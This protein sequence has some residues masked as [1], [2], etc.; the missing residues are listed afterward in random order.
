MERTAL[1][2]LL[3]QKFQTHRIIGLLG[4]RQCGKTTLAKAYCQKFPDFSR[5]NYFDLENPNDLG[6][7]HEPYQ[8]LKDLNGLII[9]D[10]IQRAPEIFPILRV[11][12]DEF[13]N[14]KFLIL[15]SASKHLLHQSS[16]S[17][18][19]RIHYEEVTPFSFLEV[20][21]W[22]SLWFRGGFPRSYL[23]DSDIH[24]LEWREDYVRT[25]LEQDV[26]NLGFRIPAIHLR[27]F[28]M[29]LAN[30]HGQIFNAHE[31]GQSLD[32]SAQS[33]RR[34]LDL[35][36][37]MLMVR[38]LQPW[39]AN[40]GKRQVKSPKSYIRDSGIFHYLAHITNQDTFALSPKRGTSFEGFVIEEVIRTMKAR[41]ENCFYWR[42]HG[43]LELDLMILR[44][45]QKI[46]F[47]VKMTDK[48]TMT[49]SMHAAHHDL[50][51]DHLYLI[52]PGDVSWPLSSAS[53][54]LGLSDLPQLPQKFLG[55]QP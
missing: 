10:E 33:M 48:P 45:D 42:T 5:R 36:Q 1:L 30:C 9:I 35:L 38:I 50:A 41:P 52:H 4:P 19:G 46:G 13:D 49:K 17:L 15:G 8:S 24:S 2:N 55:K 14:K 51:L 43:G 39:H 28:W 22:K 47:E 32:L 23:A 31:I 7:L 6:R 34:Y 37:D 21:E 25:L 27:R 16:E 26:P 29:M 20:H 12:H 54:A 11:L 3:D 40:I 18:T 44:G 53:T